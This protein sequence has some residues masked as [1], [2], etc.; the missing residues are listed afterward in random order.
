MKKPT[1]WP[2]R[3]YP[4]GA[5]VDEGGV[6]FALYTEHATAVE[7]CLFDASG[8]ETRVR[9]PEYTN[10]VWHAY[11][12]GLLSGQLYG[13]RVS[14]AYEPEHGHRF[15]PAKLLL[16]PYAQAISGPVEWERGAPVFGYLLDDPRTDLSQDR[17]DSAP[18]LPKSVVVDGRYDW[19][20]DALPRVPWADTVIYEAHVKGLTARHPDVPTDLRGRYAAL[21]S[22][23]IVNHLQTL[24]ITAIEL[25]PVQAFVNDRSL[26]EKG[27]G[28]YWGYNTI[29]FFAPEAR[30]ASRGTLG[31]QVTEFKDMVKAFHR[32]GLEV[33]LD[34]VYN[35]TGEGNQLGPTLCFRGLDNA[36]Y[37]LLVDKDRRY[38]LDYTGTGNTLNTRR[39]NVL[40]LICDSLR[41]WVQA[42]H[43]DGF[44]FDLATA[45]ARD[46]GLYDA[47]SGFL[48]AVRQDPVLSQVK[49]IAEPWDVGDGGYQVGGFP[50]GWSEWN[51]RYRDTVREFWRGEGSTLGDLASRFTG[52]SDLYRHAGRQPNR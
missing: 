48:T 29:G 5:T 44:R 12:P 30:Y 42:M 45:L 41:Y 34:V 26:I 1:V 6:N 22:P 52:S 51:G 11:L 25:L 38:T 39:P 24:G 3:P 21:A 27:L 18:Y 10:Q 17:N 7:L 16:D 35:H 31:Q 20:G 32:T 9:L 19:E 43:V 50:A 40:Q 28:N 8:Q 49:L 37:Y 13:Y 2:G 14:G 36:A 33:I 23:P 46:G 47:W 15:N 4:L